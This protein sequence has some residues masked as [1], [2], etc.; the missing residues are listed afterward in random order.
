MYDSHRAVAA[1]GV[2]KGVDGDGQTLG[3]VQGVGQGSLSVPAVV[4]LE[5]MEGMEE[6]MTWRTGITW[7]T[8]RTGR[9]RR[10]RMT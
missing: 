2:I 1:R 7:R 6:W 4:G 5:S 10:T 3:M 9:T 8:Q